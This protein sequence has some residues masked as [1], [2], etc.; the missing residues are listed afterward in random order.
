[1]SSRRELHR[2]WH[3]TGGLWHASEHRP[4]CEWHASCGSLSASGSGTPSKEGRACHSPLKSFEKQ[5]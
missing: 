2:E 1:M 4:G 5:P 3:S